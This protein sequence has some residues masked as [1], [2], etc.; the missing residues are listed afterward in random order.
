MVNLDLPNLRSIKLGWYAFADSL[1]THIESKYVI[2][3][4][5][6]YRPSF[7]AIYSTWWI[8]ISWR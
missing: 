8:C 5:N 2:I 6:Y 7:I 3:K 4:D 1:A